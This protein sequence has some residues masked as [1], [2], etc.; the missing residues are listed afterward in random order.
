MST[1]S[2]LLFSSQTGQWTSHTN[3]AWYDWYSC[4]FKYPKHQVTRE[5]KY[6]GARHNDYFGLNIFH[7]NRKRVQ[8]RTQR[9]SE[10]DAI[11][12]D[13]V[14][15]AMLSQRCGIS[16]GRLDLGLQKQEGIGVN[17]HV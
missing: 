4:I 17:A 3:C 9:M 2:A 5:H 12:D 7:Q 1:I 11:A 8:K 10:R 15:K 14:I 16:K 6:A 13:H